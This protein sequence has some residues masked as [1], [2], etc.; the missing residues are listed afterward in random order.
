M[1]VKVLY[2]LGFHGGEDSSL[3]LLETARP[4]ETS[5]SWPLHYT[6]SQPRRPQL[7]TEK[8]T[9]SVFRSAL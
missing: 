1:N 3:G 4:S 2:T 7:E 6:A 9:E 8:N 5:I